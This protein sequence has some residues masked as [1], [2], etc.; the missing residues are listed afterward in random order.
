[1]YV[2]TVVAACRQAGYDPKSFPVRNTGV[3]V[4]HTRPGTVS[5]EWA[6]RFT[7]PETISYLDK[8]P[9]FQGVV[10]DVAAFYR[11]LQERAT[12]NLAKVPE[13]FR[14]LYLSSDLARLVGETLKLDGPGMVFNSACASSLHAISQATLALRRGRID[15][16]IVGGSTFFHSDTLLLFASSRSMTTKRSCPFDKDADGLVVG[17]GSVALILKRLSDALAAKDPIMA[18]ITGIGIASDGKGKSLWAPRKE[19]QIEA[20]RKAY[21]SGLN[22]SDVD[23]VEAHAT[24]TALGDA[25]ELEALQESL[26]D[27]LRGRRIPLGS[28]KGNIGHTL[29]VAGA[30]GVLKAALTLSTGIVPPVGGLRA[31]NPKIPWSDIPFYAPMELE[32]LAPAPNGRARRAACNSFGIGG[33]NVH[34]AL[35]EYLSD[36]WRD[37]ASSR[38]QTSV[39]MAT[40]NIET[41]VVAIVGMGCI[42]PDAY[43][44]DAFEKL[45]ESDVNVFRKIPSAVWELDVFRHDYSGRDFS[46]APEF[47]AGVIDEYAYDWKKNKVPPKQVANASPIQFMMLDATNEALATLGELTADQRRRSGVVVGSGFGG[48]FSNKMNAVLGLPRFERVLSDALRDEGVA[49][50]QIDTILAEYS[51]VLHKRMPAL[52]DE[53]GSFTP[54]AL[55]SRITKTLDLGGGAVAVDSASGSFGAALMCATDQ[56]LARCNDMM[57]VIGGQQDLGPGVFDLLYATGRLSTEPQLSPFDAQANGGAPGEGCGVLL[58]KRLEDAKRDGD[59]VLAVIEKVGVA[60]NR[61]VYDNVML[62]ATRAVAS[63][64]RP[65]VAE[66]P[67]AGQDS[68]VDY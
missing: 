66:L 14:P 15:A 46:K 49:Q 13:G 22:T 1:A 8:I 57:V 56:L 48:D 7:Y 51:E 41:E 18:L 36:Y 24:S 68:D 31:P 54:S 20:I 65:D 29:E 27:A 50:E 38:N 28:A 26:G 59:E 35:D 10:K 67:V 11:R 63:S 39:S 42:F 44:V 9:L 19:G 6:Y 33:L 25:T 5:Q 53:T 58:I 55:A 34:V 23:Y 37:E 47:V 4:G 16:A 40:S 12:Q 43:S 21:V 2:D 45:L 52:L 64:V 62:A 30:A 17:E 60:S 32:K 61:S 3:F